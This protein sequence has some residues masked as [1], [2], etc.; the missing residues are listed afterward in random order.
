MC[1]SAV[2]NNVADASLR[3]VFCA[4]CRTLYHQ[5]CWEQSGGKCAILGC[6]HD[7]YIVYGTPTRPVLVIKRADL[8]QPSPNGRRGTRQT[9]QLKA[10]QR[11][12]VERLRRPSLLRRLWQWLLDQIK[13]G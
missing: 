8:P 13:I 12:Q 2:E 9:K 11:R 5:A 1:A 10:E 4:N 6:D 7:K 3:P